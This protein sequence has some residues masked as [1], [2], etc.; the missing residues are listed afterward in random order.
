MITGVILAHNE[1][2]N[3][4]ACIEALRPH[5]QELLLID[6]ES[7]D[8]TREIAAPLVSRVLTHPNLPNFDAIRNIAIPESKFDWMWFVDADERIPDITGKVVRELIREQGT[9]FEAICIPFKTYFCG[10][11]MQHCGWWPGYTC[12][13]V[14]KR[15]YFEFSPTL[16]G[17]VRL[18]GREIRVVP[19]PK[20]AVE[21]KSYRSV[22][23]WLVK[24]NRYTSTEALQ[25]AKR[26]TTW[27]W[28]A[29]NRD[30]IRDLWEHYEFRNARL[31]GDRGWMLTW[32]NAQYRWQSFAKLIDHGNHLEAHGGPS[33]VPGSLDD[34]LNALRID[35][36]TYRATRPVFPLG[37]LLRLDFADGPQSSWRLLKEFAATNRPTS[38]QL[39][40]AAC[41][42]LQAADDRIL[43][44]ALNRALPA[45]HVVAITK[46]S[47]STLPIDQT[48]V[49]NIIWCNDEYVNRLSDWPSVNDE[50]NEIWIT[51]SK[52]QH[53]LIALGASPERVVIV[54]SVDPAASQLEESL[55]RLELT[56]SPNDPKKKPGAI[57]VQIEGECLG[58][59]SFAN[60]NEQIA[61]RLAEAPGIDISISR[62]HNLFPCDPHLLPNIDRRH[63]EYQNVR[64]YFGHDFGDPDVIIRH[65]YP[66][67]WIKPLSGKWVHIQ[68]WEYGSLP[69]LWRRPLI[70]DVD[71]IWTM[72][73]YVT[74]VYIKSGV[75]AEKLH[76]VPWGVDPVVFNPDAVK[77]KLPTN[78]S[79]R[80]LYIGGLT[81]RKGFD[82][83][84]A[85]FVAEFRPD[86]DVALVVKDV[87]SNSVY[88]NQTLREQLVA[89][90]NDSSLPSIVYFDREMTAGQLASLYA[91][92]N[93]FVAPYRGEG[94]GLPILEAMAVGL[95]PLVPDLGPAID[96]TD[97]DCSIRIPGRFVAI[98]QGDDT[99]AESE[100][101]IE[102]QDLRRAMRTAY[103]NK[104]QIFERGILASQKVRREFT[105]R[106]T[107]NR[108]LARLQ[109]LSCRSILGNR[110]EVV[111]EKPALLGATVVA[112]GDMGALTFSLAA[113]QPFI[114]NL[115]IL[116]EDED[117]RVDLIASEYNVYLTRRNGDC[118]DKLRSSDWTLMLGAGEYLTPDD[119]VQIERTLEGVGDDVCFGTLKH[120]GNDIVRLARKAHLDR[121][122]R[123][124]PRIGEV[125]AKFSQSI[126]VGV[127][128]IPNNSPISPDTQTGHSICDSQI[129]CSAMSD[130]HAEVVKL[131]VK[132][133]TSRPALFT[134][135][136]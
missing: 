57:R 114:K 68:P 48:A 75:P 42:V 60:I 126:R 128:T 52:A 84:L 65:A 82:R 86:D 109:A 91:A 130:E 22:E 119:I 87:G 9:D 103:E 104:D 24:S 1:E 40:T 122:L 44:S 11:W 81:R 61:K 41:P 58:D 77:R 117:E 3:I 85:A 20:L 70:E 132:D 50:Y 71:E 101:E 51:S 127:A 26:G 21:H 98:E 92:C 107:V 73:H 134:E 124:S 64:K 30:F 136:W 95:C 6:T 99:L 72:S 54:N 121:L 120:D 94:F 25:L 125:V 111:V 33:S 62:K 135:A 76:Y 45:Q 96:Y 16:H 36:A 28:R 67:N 97:I 74:D 35:L 49:A 100:I 78:K 88:L 115:V 43:L 38:C 89:L 32:L 17:G 13:R 39:I 90:L 18:N 133:P 19:D 53:Q 29:A 8:R 129:S 118:N 47:S 56:L 80:F 108:M 34:V 46:P 69:Q 10:K 12:P 102:M 83:V 110:G 27:D 131:G 5:V 15:G 37:I 4:L 23:H 31:D 106:H 123:I 7:T 55:R 112:N 105:W 14:L 116:A 93:C 79:F 113:T 59:H 2:T 66:P 63:T